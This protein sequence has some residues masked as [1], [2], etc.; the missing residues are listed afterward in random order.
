[1]QL[2]YPFETPAM[3]NKMSIS[4]LLNDDDSHNTWVDIHSD[5]TAL[6]ELAG[7]GSV[8][9]PQNIAL[10]LSKVLNYVRDNVAHKRNLTPGASNSSS[11]LPLIVEGN[12][13]AVKTKRKVKMNR[14]T[15]ID[16]LYEYTDPLASVEYPETSPDIVGYLFK[17]DPS[18]WRDPSSDFVYSLGKPGGSLSASRTPQCLILVNHLG[19]TVPCRET[20]TTCQGSKVCPF[21]NME[22]LRVPHTSATTTAITERLSKDRTLRLE[23]CSPKHDVFRK[24]AAL[25]S[26]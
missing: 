24:T 25:I 10:A 19:E 18:D 21:T 17:R 14:Q 20:H 7:N 11:S 15:T 23:A 6:S 13:T 26:A 22:L 1:M 5:L 2:L 4:S 3:S 12:T 8:L 16:I 9:V